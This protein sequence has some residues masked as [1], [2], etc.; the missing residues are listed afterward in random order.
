MERRMPLAG[1]TAIDIKAITATRDCLHAYTLVFGG[2]LRSSRV[3]DVR[4]VLP[5]R[6]MDRHWLKLSQMRI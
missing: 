3:A 1:F 4:E 6:M 5:G 2:Y